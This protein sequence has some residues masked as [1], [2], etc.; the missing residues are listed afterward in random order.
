MKIKFNVIFPIL[1]QYTMM[2]IAQVILGRDGFHWMHLLQALVPTIIVTV[3]R[4]A[5]G[6]YRKKEKN[7]VV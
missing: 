5:I 4:S 6:N 2:V 3:V 1:I 7:K